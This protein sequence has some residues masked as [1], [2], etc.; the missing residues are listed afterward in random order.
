MTG[1]TGN[2]SSGEGHFGDGA[3]SDSRLPLYQRLRDDIHGR[4]VANGWSADDP[5]PSENVLARDYGVAVGTARKAIETLV[6]EGLLVRRRGRGTFIRRPDFA[7]SLF[8]F[9][10]V[11]T[12][13]GTPLIP[14]GQVLE[15]RVEPAGAEVAKRLRLPEGTPVIHFHRLRLIE[16]KPLLVEL[17]WLPEE[18]FRPLLDIAVPDYP[19]LMYPLYERACGQLV[20]RAGEDLWVDTAAEAEAGLLGIDAGTPVVRIGRTASGFD[21]VPLEWRVSTGT[22]ASFRYHVEIR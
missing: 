1:T 2:Q 20:A 13:D 11:R 4:I 22:A 16:G 6:A 8:R 15:R 7:S 12:A 3:V 17:I 10:R 9:F 18:P 5:L 14:S 19:D 21:A